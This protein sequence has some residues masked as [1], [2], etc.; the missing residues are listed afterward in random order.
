MHSKMVT[1]VLNV[2]YGE[3]FDSTMSPPA[4]GTSQ[5]VIYTALAGVSTRRKRL[6]FYNSCAIH[7]L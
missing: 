6:S 3:R 2:D 5:R 4:T 1:C 7:S